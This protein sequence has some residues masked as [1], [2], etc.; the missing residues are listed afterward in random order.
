M[1]P[2]RSPGFNVLTNPP[3][4]LKLELLPITAGE[5]EGHVSVYNEPVVVVPDFLM[6]IPDAP[7]HS[8]PH[9]IPSVSANFQVVAEVPRLVETEVV[10]KIA[11]NLQQ[12]L[13]VVS[14]K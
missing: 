2:L 5:E 8:P 3:S 4:D 9:H 1:K 6:V 14:L 12:V 7:R 13:A 10:A 11:K